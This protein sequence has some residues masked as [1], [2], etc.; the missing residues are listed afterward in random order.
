M[1]L[2]S[3]FSSLNAVQYGEGCGVLPP[4]FL[5]ARI[6]GKETSERSSTYGYDHA[7]MSRHGR[8]YGQRQPHA[9]ICNAT[10]G[11]DQLGAIQ[12][13]CGNERTTTNEQHVHNVPKSGSEPH[14]PGI[15]LCCD[16]K[17]RWAWKLFSSHDDGVPGI[18]E[19]R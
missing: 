9:S 12:T 5:L 11:D 8:L 13:A 15:F 7:A 10:I 3:S 18:L 14:F 2:S 1:H 6:M 17:N 16:N 19:M 4:E